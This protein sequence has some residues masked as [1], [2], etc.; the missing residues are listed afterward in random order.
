M[1]FTR[2]T[3]ADKPATNPPQAWAVHH[4]VV[5]HGEFHSLTTCGL[6]RYGADD[7]ARVLK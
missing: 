6:T 2:E 4:R 1:P 7:C 5:I 3:T